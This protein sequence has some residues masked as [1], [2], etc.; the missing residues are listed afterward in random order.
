MPADKQPELHVG[1]PTSYLPEIGNRPHI[2]DPALRHYPHGFRQGDPKFAD[3]STRLY[4]EWMQQEAMTHLLGITKACSWK[5]GPILRGSVVLW[6]YLG[7]QARVPRDLDWL[8]QPTSLKP[9]SPL[10]QDFFREVVARLRDEPS[11]G[12]GAFEPDEIRY[13]DIWVYDKS[14]GLRLVFPWYAQNMPVGMVQM[15]FAFQ[16]PLPTAPVYLDLPGASGVRAASLEQLLAWKLYW[17]KEDDYPQGK[18]LYDATLIA[19]HLY[20]AGTPYSFDLPDTLVS[21]VYWDDFLSEY[22][23]VQGDPASWA[24]RLRAAL[25]L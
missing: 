17:L 20:A 18:D 1:Y 14:P 10:I 6:H 13:D 21:D 24:K 22:P 7:G 3:E 12:S 11:F 16:E 15:D 2:F 25:T 4:W 9:D 23:D 5:D 19:E 8:V